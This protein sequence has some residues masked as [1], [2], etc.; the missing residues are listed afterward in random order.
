LIAQIRSES[1][2]T[3]HAPDDEAVHEFGDLPMR[4]ARHRPNRQPRGCAGRQLSALSDTVAALTGPALTPTAT[5]RRI[6]LTASSDRDSSHNDPQPARR[7]ARQ[8]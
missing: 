1:R 4:R 5:V 2:R 7:P 3:R 8:T 6:Q